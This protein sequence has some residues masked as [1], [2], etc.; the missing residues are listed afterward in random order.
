MQ[1]AG[2]KVINTNNQKISMSREINDIDCLLTF[3]ELRLRGVTEND[4]FSVTENED[5]GNVNLTVYFYRLE[6]HEELTDRIKTETQYNINYI[7]HRIKQKELRKK[8]KSLG[9]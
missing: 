4:S 7:N 9:N 8:Y 6:T 2:P 3:E 1:Y 5:T